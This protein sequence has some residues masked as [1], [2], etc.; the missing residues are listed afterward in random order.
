MSMI[1]TA[2]Q[3][4]DERQ[5][6]AD[7]LS[8][9]PD[10]RLYYVINFLQDMTSPEIAE[11]PFY[12]KSNMDFIKEGIQTLENGKGVEHDIVEDYEQGKNGLTESGTTTNTGY[13]MTRKSWKES[14][15]CLL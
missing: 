15:S 11:D 10:N 14:T 13:P 9:I 3:P 2:T 7:L 8:T 4:T 5:K 12:S 1:K 6:A